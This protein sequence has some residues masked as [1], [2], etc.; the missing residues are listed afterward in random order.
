MEFGLLGPVSV[1]IDGEDVEVRGAHPRATLALLLLH[2]RSVVSVTQLVDGLWGNN[3]PV[4]ARLGVQTHIKRLRQMLGPAG[5]ERLTTQQP[6]YRLHVE[7][8]ELDLDRFQH[9]VTLARAAAA[10]E[11]WELAAA[12]LSRALALWR[13]EP[14]Q[15]VPQSA[16]IRNEARRLTELRLQCL[17]WRIDADLRSGRAGE[18]VAELRRLTASHPLHERFWGQLMVALSRCGRQAEA[19]A[20]FHQARAVL[21]DELGVLPSPQL[22]ALQRKL[23]R[24][25]DAGARSEDHVEAATADSFGADLSRPATRLSA[26][27]PAA[28]TRPAG[29]L[30]DQLPS[31]IPDFT[32]REPEIASIVER[33]RPDLADDLGPLSWPVPLTVV[34]GPGGIGKTA[35]AV[36]AAHLLRPHYPGGCLFVSFAGDGAGPDDHHAVLG[37][38]LR[39]LGVPPD[40]VPDDH[41]EATALYRSVLAGRRILLLID[42]ATHPDQVAMLVP[43]AA[44]C[45]VLVTS[46]SALAG[47][48]G[49]F[50]VTLAELSTA[51]AGALIRGIVGPART[52]DAAEAVTRLCG[53]CGNLPLALRI[54]GTRLALRPGWAVWDLVEDLSANG[55]VM[56]PERSDE[57]TRRLVVGLG[58]NGLS[59]P[60][61]R[62]F[63][64]LA[65]TSLREFSIQVAA[66]LLGTDVRDARR[67]AER[68]VDVHLL[69]SASRDEYRLRELHYQYARQQLDRLEPELRRDAVCRVTRYYLDTIAELAQAVLCPTRTT[70]G[71]AGAAAWLDSQGSNVEA[72]AAD[73]RDPWIDDPAAADQLTAG[74]DALT[75]I[76]TH[77]VAH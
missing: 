56:D 41:R 13:A 53:L 42:G 32:G 20:A 50:R 11:S 76:L 40:A 36:H 52:D 71:E 34:T 59:E 37:R 47:L 46:R 62:A 1:R 31:D 45:A 64:L 18:L 61:A 66:A 6:G 9:L 3:P 29:T 17:E 28:G 75:A 19:F 73:N 74:L 4:R 35:L 65:A 49:A 22:Q 55:W 30:P 58:H 54:A 63:R 27:S 38:V 10:V 77:A 16:M 67:T 57:A 44:D 15:D 12:E 23:L 25:E 72:L 39:A 60:D 70:A 43:G 68:L 51:Q 5:V 48:D 24:I 8:D 2:R 69:S 7:P 26:G 33:L 21:H 14:L